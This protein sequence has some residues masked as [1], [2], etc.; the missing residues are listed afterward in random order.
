MMKNTELLLLLAS[1]GALVQG[2]RITTQQAA[3]ELGISQQ[4]ASRWMREAQAQGFMERAG[5]GVMLTQKAAQELR[6]MHASLSA[7]L[8]LPKSV[9]IT[10][11]VFSGMRDGRYY[12][13][14]GGYRR[15]LLEKMG[16]KPFAGTLNLR[17]DAENGAKRAL[18]AAQPGVA[19][20]GFE[21]GSRFFGP[22]KCFGALV[23]NLR[24]AAILPQRS[25]YG[26]DT[27]EI[28][29]KDDL[30]KALGLKDGSVVTVRVFLS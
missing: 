22:A 26:A 20:K 16:F 23:R 27:L 7:A 24:C 30:R 2:V 4:S 1:R 13:S 21:E 6:G 5:A 18:L 11:I 8:R 28:I 9:D 17:L 10:G 25:H 12:M 19:L 29:A 15:Q 14:R 3:H